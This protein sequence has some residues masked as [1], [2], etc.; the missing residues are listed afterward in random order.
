MLDVL[1]DFLNHDVLPM[2]RRE[3]EKAKEGTALA[4]V[5]STI[6]LKPRLKE[7]V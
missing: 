6:T 4:F 3:M 7:G 2:I 1:R 5:G